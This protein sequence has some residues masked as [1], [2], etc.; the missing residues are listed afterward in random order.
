EQLSLAGSGASTTGALRNVSGNNSVDGTITLTAATRINSDADI[1][2]LTGGISGTQ[3]L[4]VGG[5]GATN[6]SGIIGTGTG[7]LTKDGVGTVTLSAANIYD[8]ATTVS[9]GTLNVRNAS[10][11]G[12]TVGGTTVATGA[13]LSIENSTTVTGEALSLSGTGVSNGGA[14][15]SVSGDNAYTG[16][17]T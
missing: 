13:A 15:R 10:A 8:G 7:A 3:N 14:L 11:L 16:A 6:I 17:I 5:A 9:V 4:T 2:T 12:T 1:L